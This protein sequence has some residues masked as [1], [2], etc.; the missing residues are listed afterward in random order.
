MKTFLYLFLFD[1]NIL[2][3]YKRFFV[4]FKNLIDL[5]IKFRSFII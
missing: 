3:T 2:K 5:L 4:K 1:F